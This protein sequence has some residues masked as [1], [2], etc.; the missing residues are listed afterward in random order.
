MPAPPLS[1]HEILG[2][3]EPFT[4]HGRHVDLAG[5]DRLQRRIAFK[6]LDHDGA[7][8]G[9]LPLRETLQLESLGTGTFRLTRTL[10][11]RGGL[12]ATLLAM[13]SQPVDLLAGVEAIAA[14][15]QFRAGPGFLIARCYELKPA[16]S[17]EDGLILTSGVVRLDGLTLTLTVSPVRGVSGDLALAPTTDETLDLPQDLLAVL[18]WDWTRLVPHKDGWKSKVRLRGRA[19]QR[20]RRALAALDAAAEHLATTLAQPPARYHEQHLSA[21]WGVVFRR[22]IPSLTAISLIA[23]VILLP[24]FAVDENPGL[25][26]LMYHVPT[27]LLALSFCLQELPQFEVPPLPRKP[28]SSSWRRA[29]STNGLTSLPGR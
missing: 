8:T 13:G 26:M 24:R 4:R 3:V 27:V 29:R 9:A 23:T 10:T 18:G 12:Q 22:A 21:R 5:S 14:Q 20:T 25:W 6:P 1:H 19:A 28:T 2:L 15:R 17:V 11:A 16:P 7:A